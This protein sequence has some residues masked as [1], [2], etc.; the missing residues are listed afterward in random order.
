MYLAILVNLVNMVN[1]C[2]SG[3]SGDSGESCDSGESRKIQVSEDSKWHEPDGIYAHTF[4]QD[5]YYLHILGYIHSYKNFIFFTPR[6]SLLA[7]SMSGNRSP[8]RHQ[9]PGAWQEIYRRLFLL[10]ETHGRGGGGE[11]GGG[12]GG[13]RQQ[14]QTPGAWQE[15]CRRLAL[16][17]STPHIS[18]SIFFSLFSL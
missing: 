10:L 9:T 2:E 15:I 17:I 8:L 6:S 12:R 4:T 7:V 3:E 18:T 16:F 14:H 1:L 11:G 5:R 13:G